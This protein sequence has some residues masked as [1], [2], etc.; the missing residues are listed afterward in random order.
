MKE[1]LIKFILLVASWFGYGKEVAAAEAYQAE[2]Q[3]EDAE[4]IEHKVAE[5]QET[6]TRI[7]A[8]EEKDHEKVANASDP[9][10]AAID[11]LRSDGIITPDPENDPGTDK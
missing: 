5:I 6:E 8:Q 2:G 10:S 1:I 9:G 11:L 3:R 7:R 4:A